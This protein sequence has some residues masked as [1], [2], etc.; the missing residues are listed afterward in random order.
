MKLRVRVLKQVL[1]I[2]QIRCACLLLFARNA[3]LRKRRA[4]PRPT[5]RSFAGCSPSTKTNVLDWRERLVCSRCGSRQV[6]MVATGKAA[7]IDRERTSGAWVAEE[8]GVG[9]EVGARERLR[10]NRYR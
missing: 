1:R 9:P 8:F 2:A 6:D 4:E 3:A 5:V 7:I 10:A